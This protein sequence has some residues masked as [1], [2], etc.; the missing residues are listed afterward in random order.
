MKFKELNENTYFVSTL[1]FVAPFARN[2]S[3]SLVYV[4]LSEIDLIQQREEAGGFWF[5]TYVLTRSGQLWSIQIKNMT[6]FVIDPRHADSMTSASIL[7]VTTA[8][9]SRILGS[10]FQS[11][12]I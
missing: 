7:R 11:L 8:A 12:Y 9:E 4:V 5:F 2:L 10:Q 3:R 1:V 6:A